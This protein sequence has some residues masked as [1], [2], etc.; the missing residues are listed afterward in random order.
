MYFEPEEFYKTFNLNHFDIKQRYNSYLLDLG[1]DKVKELNRPLSFVSEEDFKTSLKLDI[2]FTYLLAIETLFELVFSLLPEEGK[3]VREFQIIER[4]IDDKRHYSEIRKF[5]KGEESRLDLLSKE[6]DH[7][8]IQGTF[9]RFLFYRG[10]TDPSLNDD[11]NSS[12]MI[13]DQVLRTLASEIADRSE[14]NAHKHGL[15]G[16]SVWKG[17]GF[18]NANNLEDKVE[19][20]IEDSVSYLSKSKGGYQFLTKALDPERDIKMTRLVSNLIRNIINPRKASIMNKKTAK[21]AKPSEI[22]IHFFT[23][24]TYDD[25]NTY[26]VEIDDIRQTIQFKK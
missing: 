16:V 18:A 25:F 14:I 11:V 26:H 10:I 6:L 21:G 17:F 1:D 9:L 5:S 4:L 23:Q 13:I 8:D 3:V 22:H 15:R 2:R 24:K 19:F 12:L 20:N 7:K